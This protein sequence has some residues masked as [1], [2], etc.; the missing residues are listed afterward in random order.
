MTLVGWEVRDGVLCVTLDRP[1]ANALGAPLIEGL[2]AALAEFEAGAAKVAVF[3]SAIPGFFAA[4]ADIKHMASLTPEGFRQYGDDLRAC[5]ERV[6]A[7]P[8]PTIAAIDGM[9]LGGGLELA[10]AC[11]LRFATPGSQ[12][13][14]PEVKLGLVPGAGGTQRLPRLIG[15]GRALQMT[16]TGDEVSGADA[17][18]I[19]LVD[20]LVEGDVFAEALTV[21]TRMARRS[22]AALAELLAC[23]DAAD[24]PL[25]DGLAFE[26]GAVTRL[27]AEGEGREGLDAF[28][29]KRQPM[30]E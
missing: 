4:G 16:L 5:L 18:Q 28:V 13:G 22:S 9:A 14:V 3:R 10:C 30:F 12:L 24:E 1:P 8:K 2:N 27:F 15:R 19:G 6:A 23:A 21:A 7:S 20:R 26:A 11:S 17:A 25:A 29:A